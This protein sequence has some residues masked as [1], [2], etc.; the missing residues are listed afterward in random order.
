MTST[1]SSRETV[2]KTNKKIKS[3]R[4]TIEPLFHL[5]TSKSGSVVFIELPGVEERDVDIQIHGDLITLNAI[6]YAKTDSTARPGAR[7]RFDIALERKALFTFKLTLQ[8]AEEVKEDCI[9]YDFPKRGVLRL[10]APVVI[11]ECLNDFF[12]RSK[13]PSNQLAKFFCFCSASRSQTMDKFKPCTCMF[14]Q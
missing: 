5:Q 3:I 9:R 11:T 12:D 4:P 8:L 6:K 13:K 10:E 1:R 7:V 14:R 2:K